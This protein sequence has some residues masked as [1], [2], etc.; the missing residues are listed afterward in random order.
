MNMQALM[1]QAQAMQRDI[2]KAKEEIDNTEFTGTSSIV[3]VVCNGKK[4]IISVKI[5][6][7]EAAQDVEMLEDM[8]MVAVNDAF[9]KVDLETE[10][11]LGKYSNM[12]S[13]LM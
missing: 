13:G 5:S 9:K 12:M 11:K 10:K 4:E 3:T 2:T 8:L 6:D 1:K 7:K